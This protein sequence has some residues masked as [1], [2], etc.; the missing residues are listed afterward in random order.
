MASPC[1]FSMPVNDQHDLTAVA[2]RIADILH[3]LDAARVGR[4]RQSWL[5]SSATNSEDKPSDL[6]D[7]RISPITLLF[8]TI[9]FMRWKRS[10]RPR[11][12]TG[13]QPQH[14]LAEGTDGAVLGRRALLSEIAFARRIRVRPRLGRGL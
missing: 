1:R 7:S 12:R 4:L 14:L 6:I 11:A 3:G 13:W 8:H 9:F 2:L 10:A 5:S